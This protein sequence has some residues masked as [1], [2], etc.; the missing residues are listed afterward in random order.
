MRRVS[1]AARAGQIGGVATLTEAAMRGGARPEENGGG[2]GDS[3]GGG[4]GAGSDSQS[5][6]L[7]PFHDE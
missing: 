6:N 7:G 1:L 4:A 3:I 2:G 5:N